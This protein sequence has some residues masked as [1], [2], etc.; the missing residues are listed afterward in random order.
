VPTGERAKFVIRSHDEV[1]SGGPFG[2]YTTASCAAPFV[3]LAR[4]G[5]RYKAIYTR[6]SSG[7]ALQVTE[8]AMEP[9]DSPEAVLA[10]LEQP[11]TAK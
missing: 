2:A 9:A 8:R 1:V 3:F 11:T 5:Y 7:C 10:S 6:T 4:E